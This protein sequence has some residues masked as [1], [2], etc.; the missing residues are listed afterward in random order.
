MI[1]K[2]VLKKTNSKKAH[3]STGL[4]KNFCIETNSTDTASYSFS[5]STTAA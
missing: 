3:K 5:D 4:H 1:T 2:T